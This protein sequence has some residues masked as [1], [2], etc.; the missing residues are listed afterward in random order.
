MEFLTTCRITAKNANL[1]IDL[2]LS[3]QFGYL[4]RSEWQK[5][6]QK[7]KISYNGEILARYD[8]KTRAGDVITYAGRDAAEPEVDANYT[9]L[10]ED[11]CLLAV[12]KPGNLPVHPAGVFYHNTLQTILQKE[13]NMRLYLLHRLDRETSGVIILAKNAATASE[14]R[15]TFSAVEKTYLALVHG[16]PERDVF[17]NDTP[18]GFD[19]ASGIEHKRS[20]HEHAPEAACTKFI[21]MQSKNDLTLLKAV[22]YTGRQHQIRV[23]LKHA[24]YPIVGDKLYGRDET[25]YLDFIKNG[26]TEEI[27]RRLGFKRCAL[28]SRS[29]A[30]YHP[31]LQKKI[32]IRAPLHEDMKKYINNQWGSDV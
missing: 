6:I 26:P 15:N 24:G 3:R 12:N 21:R 18:I 27:E 10:Y 23:H 8:R 16:V 32:C 13:Y 9:V 11:D 20:A 31:A 2:F 7:G 25:V 5:E 30:F 14:I 1:R 17:M 28:H 19:I 29:I 22:P 4:S